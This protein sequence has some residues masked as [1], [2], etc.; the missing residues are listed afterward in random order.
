MVCTQSQSTLR[1]RFF[2]GVYMESTGIINLWLSTA[3]LPL[4][5]SVKRS[6]SWFSSS[7]PRSRSAVAQSLSKAASEI[8]EIEYV[9]D[10][11]HDEPFL[12]D[13]DDQQTL[14]SLEKELNEL[15][16]LAGNAIFFH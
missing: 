16:N 4:S 3:N 14:D 5:N 8:S 11:D 12:D 7:H 1:E 10:T 13:A 6:S 15:R 2:S 9:D